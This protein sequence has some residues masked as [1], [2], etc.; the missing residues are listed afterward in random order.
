MGFCAQHRSVK[1][2]NHNLVVLTKIMPGL[3][4]DPADKS[5][6]GSRVNAADRKHKSVVVFDKPA[7]KRAVMVTKGMGEGMNL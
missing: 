4:S 3:I 2:P 6:M 1:T 5:E 7:N